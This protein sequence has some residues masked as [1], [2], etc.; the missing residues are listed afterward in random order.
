MTA[1]GTNHSLFLAELGQIYS[2][3]FNEFGQLGVY[4]EYVATNIMDG[5]EDGAQNNLMGNFYYVK[6]KSTPVRIH[7][8]ENI[9]FI[10]AAGSHSLAITD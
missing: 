10:A 8:L 5:L 2:S 3:G 9:R 1:A 6:T 7:T 4:T